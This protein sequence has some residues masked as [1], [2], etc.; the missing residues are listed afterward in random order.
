MPKFVFTGLVTMSMRTVVEADTVEEAREIAEGRDNCSIG[1]PWSYG[2]K[3]EDSWV[4][5]GEIDGVVEIEGDPEEVGDD[6]G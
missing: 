6:H 4:H 3:D 5:S 2:H 1:S